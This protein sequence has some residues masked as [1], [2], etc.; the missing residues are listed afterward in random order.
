MDLDQRSILDDVW[1]AC[2]YYLDR[3]WFRYL[4]SSSG[5]HHR[6]FGWYDLETRSHLA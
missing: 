3:V 4:L 6:G 2:W 1:R 5:V